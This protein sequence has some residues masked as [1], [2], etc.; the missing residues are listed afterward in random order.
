M[1]VIYNG[2][3]YNAD[4]ARS[5]LCAVFDIGTVEKPIF[6]IMDLDSPYLDVVPGI[7]YPSS[8]TIEKEEV[9]SLAAKFNPEVADRLGWAKSY[10]KSHVVLTKE[11]E[12]FADQCH[13]R[14]R[15]VRL[16]L[17]YP[18]LKGDLLK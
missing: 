11:D 5:G 17:K 12:P 18:H 9:E 16:V 7:K 1:K 15:L 8:L 13:V 3:L 2:K 6:R 10:F 4:L 14:D